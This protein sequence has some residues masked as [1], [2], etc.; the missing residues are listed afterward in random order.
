MADAPRPLPDPRSAVERTA[1]VERP[2]GVDRDDPTAGLIAQRCIVAVH[3]HPD[4]E[5]TKAAAT[6]SLHAAH[7]V[8][9][10]LVSCTDGS[11]GR[12]EGRT[13]DELAA[14][15]AGE[16]DRAAAILGYC[17]VHRL[18]HR[19]SGMRGEEPDSFAAVDPGLVAARLVEIFEREQPDAV[20]TYEP[21]Y[22]AGHP[23]HL[24][25]H[26]AAVAAFARYATTAIEQTALYGTRTHS[27][28]KL[29]AMHERLTATGRPSPYTH[30][31]RDPSA[32]PQVRNERV[33]VSEHLHVAERALRQHIS[34]VDDHDPWFFAVRAAEL[35]DIHPYDDLTVL[36]TNRR[37]ATD[38]IQAARHRATTRGFAY[39][40]DDEVGRVLAMLAAAVPDHGRIVELGTGTGVGLAW[41]LAGSDNGDRIDVVSVDTDSDLLDETAA[42][43]WPPNVRFLHGDG[44]L[45]VQDLAPVH[46]L[47]ADAAGG[48]L[49]GLDHSIAALAPGG[50]LVVDDMH[51]HLHTT[52]GLADTI[53]DVRRQLLA[54]PDLLAVEI[55]HGTG[56]IIATKTAR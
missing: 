5:S 51:P 12:R 42:A 31:V 50:V 41:L 54:H 43:D 45:H 26:R 14:H 7:G 49:H 36:A 4:D 11:A 28:A 46:L 17:S 29:R 15:R 21:A 53:D 32:D 16:L 34:Q 37:A 30:A 47:F 18:G 23:D 3:A 13:P 10:V 1:R 35:R 55:D 40:C 44:E 33:D 27:P 25:A 20:I 24:H 2:S 48:K 19:D 6:I 38:R 9:C 39:S 22:A 8:R 52:D 56:I